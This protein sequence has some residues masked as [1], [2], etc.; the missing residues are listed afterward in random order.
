MCLDCQGLGFQYGA[1][2]SRYK[3]ILQLSLAELIDL[4]WKGHTTR[5]SLRL[6]THFLKEVSI[7]AHTPLHHLSSQEIRLL[8]HGAN[9]ENAFTFKELS[10]RWIGLNAVFASIPRAAIPCCGRFSHHCSSKALAAPAKAH[11]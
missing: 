1:D 7:D 8:F 5:P 3:E 9:E 4:L 10:L 2:L 11:V 6:F